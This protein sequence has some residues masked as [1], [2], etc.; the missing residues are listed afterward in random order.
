MKD[1]FYSRTGHSNIVTVSSDSAADALSVVDIETF[2]PINAPNAARY[3]S[4]YVDK[5]YRLLYC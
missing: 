4:C 5:G 1:D 3:S 2:T